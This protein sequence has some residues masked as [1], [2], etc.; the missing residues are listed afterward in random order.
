MLMHFVAPF[1]EFGLT[2]SI[3]EPLEAALFL[4]DCQAFSSVSA[5]LGPSREALRGHVRK[6]C[7]QGEP[8]TMYF[9]NTRG[10]STAVASVMQCRSATPISFVESGLCNTPV[11]A[12]SRL[13]EHC[14]G[15]PPGNFRTLPSYQTPIPAVQCK[16]SACSLP[17]KDAATSAWA[18]LNHSQGVGK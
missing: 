10:Q 2:S 11:H 15:E 5:A 8:S 9:C 16:H 1:Q 17:K 13:C 14:E 3:T 7:Q 18:A 12:R 6:S 4:G